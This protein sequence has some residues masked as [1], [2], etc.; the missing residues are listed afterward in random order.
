MPKTYKVFVV[1]DEQVIRDLF[2]RIL[3][4]K[5]HEVISVDNG[6]DALQKVVEQS[7]DIV[8]TDIVMPGTDGI[9]TFKAFRKLKPDLPVVI[10]TGF[11]VEDKIEEAMSLGAIDYLYKPF[12][13][14]D[15]FSI[16]NKFEKKKRL[17][18][19]NDS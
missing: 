3:T 15:I 13:I 18:P 9:A 19:V 12:D 1:D 11:A 6:K 10:M 7:F 2:T 16:L 17:K 8:F 14:S 4:A 5:G